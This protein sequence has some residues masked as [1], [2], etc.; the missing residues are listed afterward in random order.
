MHTTKNTYHFAVVSDIVR[1]SGE[2]GSSPPPPPSPPPS[3]SPFFFSS[4][5]SSFFFVRAS[6]PVIAPA[7]GFSVFG[8]VGVGCGG[9]VLSAS[10]SD[11]VSFVSVD[12]VSETHRGSRNENA[13]HKRKTHKYER[14][15]VK[16]M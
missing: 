3:P 11:I 5:S 1:F 8:G 9:F 15:C 4:P 14:N 10:A 6:A 7:A 12:F 16:N 13:P 2:T